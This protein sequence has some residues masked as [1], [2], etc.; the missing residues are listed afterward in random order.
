MRDHYAK[1]LLKL[2]YSLTVKRREHR[3][4]YCADISKKGDNIGA[5]FIK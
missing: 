3:R 4:N 2:G 5:N 1:P